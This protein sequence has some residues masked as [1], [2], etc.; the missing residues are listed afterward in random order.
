MRLRTIA[1]ELN[2]KVRDPNPN[3]EKEGPDKVASFD[4]TEDPREA[5]KR[6]INNQ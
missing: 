2:L 5:L 1:E 4:I 3:A 6:L